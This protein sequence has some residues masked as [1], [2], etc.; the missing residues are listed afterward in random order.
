MFPNPPKH[1]LFHVSAKHA[2]H[3]LV[4]PAIYESNVCLS[5]LFL[6]CTVTHHHQ[7]HVIHSVLARKPAKRSE[8]EDLYVN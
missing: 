5:V 4:S 6:K 1:T 7:S 8:L 2:W 3:P